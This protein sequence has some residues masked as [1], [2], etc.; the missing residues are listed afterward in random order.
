[1]HVLDYWR[2]YILEQ[3]LS[4]RAIPELI[5]GGFG[6]ALS[7]FCIPVARQKC[8][9]RQFCFICFIFF[10]FIS[11]YNLIIIIII[12]DYYFYIFIYFFF[13]FCFFVFIFFFHSLFFIYLSNYY[14]VFFYF[15]FYSFLSKQNFIK[16]Y[17][18]AQE[19]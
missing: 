3:S 8:I 19:L 14:Y 6:K 18:V 12:Y 10:L 4:V 9:N 15:F 1:M 16:I 13:L 5:V 2:V 17:H 11:Y 7:P